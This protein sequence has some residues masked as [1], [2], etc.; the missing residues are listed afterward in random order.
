MKSCPTL[1]TYPFYSEPDSTPSRY[2]DLESPFCITEKETECWPLPSTYITLES[3]S[4]GRWF[5]FLLVVFTILTIRD[6]WWINTFKLK[7]IKIPIK[8]LHLPHHLESFK[9]L[10]CSQNGLFKTRNQQIK[11]TLPFSK[12]VYISLERYIL[13]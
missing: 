5:H 11:L 4:S 12:P 8:E 13:A 3:F 9:L 6:W 1:V 7:I 10:G 2:H